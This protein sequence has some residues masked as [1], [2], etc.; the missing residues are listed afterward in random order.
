MKQPTVRRSALRRFAA[1]TLVELLVVIGIIALLIAI[2]L[3]AL[4]RALGASREVKCLA[5][6]RAIGQAAVLHAHDHKGYFPVAGALWGP[7][8]S[9]TP[10]GLFDSA[11]IKYSYYTDGN[12][13]RP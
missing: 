13:T 7:A 1:F 4:S 2:L 10:A 8:T 3:P 5:N 9:A 6:L 12:N 11:K